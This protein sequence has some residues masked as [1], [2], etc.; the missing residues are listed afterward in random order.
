MNVDRCGGGAVSSK[1]GLTFEATFFWDFFGFFLSFSL[2]FVNRV[3]GTLLLWLRLAAAFE[4]QMAPS[5]LFGYL[6]SRD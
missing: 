5:L 2:V 3:G 6:V 1:F 4:D